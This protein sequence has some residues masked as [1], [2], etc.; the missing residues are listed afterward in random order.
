MRNLYQVLGVTPVADDKQLKDAFHNLAKTF[1]P[2]LNAGDPLA[3]RFKEINQAYATL[4][5]PKARAAYD[6]GLADQRSIA[7]R[8]VSKAAITG[9]A[10][11]M[12]STIVISLTMIWLLTDG[13]QVSPSRT[14]RE[15]IRPKAIVGAAQVPREEDPDARA[16]EAGRISRAE[17]VQ[18]H[19]SQPSPDPQGPLPPCNALLAEQEPGLLKMT[20]VDQPRARSSIIV[21]VDDLPYRATF[22]TDGRL[23]LVMPRIS[24]TPVLQWAL[25][26]G[27]PCRQLATTTRSGWVRVA[28]I[29]AGNADLQMHMIEPNSWLGSPVGHISSAKPNL[30]GSHGAGRF[31]TFGLPGDSLRVQLFVVDPARLGDRRFLNA[32]VVL[33]PTAAGNC[34]E[35]GAASEVRYQVYIQDS[36]PGEVRHPEVRSM[37]FQLPR[38]GEPESNRVRSE[39]V[40]VRF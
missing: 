20:L 14:D 2:D 23:T 18:A 36:R 6:Q 9:F 15:V 12:L 11:S 27:T 25:V 3:E 34:S 33:N 13:K 39:N 16:D 8:R 10:T 1:H 35:V 19:N 7:R 37:A 29:W 21:K 24:D 17:E 4:S 26:D 28:L 38:C 32:L 40:V 5:D 30:D 22:A 31:R